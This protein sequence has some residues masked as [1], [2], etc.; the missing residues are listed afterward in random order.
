MLSVGSLLRIAECLVDSVL[1]FACPSLVGASSTCQSPKHT[2]FQQQLSTVG[3]A[4]SAIPSLD[5]RVIVARAAILAG[6][7]AVADKFDVAVGAADAV[8]ERRFSVFVVRGLTCVLESLSDLFLV[9]SYN[10]ELQFIQTCPSKAYQ[11]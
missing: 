9:V 8:E 3:Q 2:N 1:V 7:V 5:A 4:L 11:C 6:N 10:N